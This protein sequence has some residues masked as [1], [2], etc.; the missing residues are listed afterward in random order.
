MRW[1]CLLRLEIEKRE[2]ER[3]ESGWGQDQTA[4]ELDGIYTFLPLDP[5]PRNWV[6]LFVIPFPVSKGEE[7]K[8]FLKLHSNL[9][10]QCGI[11]KIPDSRT[12]VSS[13][14]G[15]GWI[16]ER[17]SMV[18]ASSISPFP[19][20][21]MPRSTRTAWFTDA[22]EE[23]RRQGSKMSGAGTTKRSLRRNLLS[24][25]GKKTFLARL[26]PFS[27]VRFPK[28][29]GQEK[30]RILIC[31]EAEKVVQAAARI[32]AKSENEGQK[33]LFSRFNRQRA[34]TLTLKLK[35]KNS[36]CDRLSYGEESWENNSKKWNPKTSRFVSFRFS[37]YVTIENL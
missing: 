6:V 23:N 16:D 30:C 12:T 5:S 21:F 14:L 4:F 10:S 33:R 31:C 11:R 1:G 17:N 19:H 29:R 26:E 24:T 15:A 34:L 7:R 13:G 36:K 27:D 2:E 18:S 3:E 32:E 37:S 25:W 20:F 8:M 28:R 9:R 22:D 35:E